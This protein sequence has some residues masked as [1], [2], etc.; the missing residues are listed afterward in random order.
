MRELW[1]CPEC[2]NEFVTPNMWHSCGVFSLDD[3][4][5]RSQPH[6]RDVYDALERMVLEL[7]DVKVVPQKTRVVFQTRTRFAG[8]TPKKDYFD[9]SFIFYKRKS[10]MRIYRVNDYEGKWFGHHAKLYEVNDVDEEVRGWLIEA[11]RY[12]DQLEPEE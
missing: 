5:A 1:V 9:A 4:F 10:N 3:L 11:M 7:G 8:G 12:G 6:I 2:G